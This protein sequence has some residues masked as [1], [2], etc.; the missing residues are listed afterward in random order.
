MSF[1]EILAHAV[2]AKN[3]FGRYGGSSPA[4]FVMGK[5]HP[6]LDGAEAVPPNE[7]STLET[8]LQRKTAAIKAFMESEAKAMLCL[9]LHAR[10]RT[11][12]QPEPG[13]I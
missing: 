11:L 12:L 8:H 13:Q 7:L 2:A 10:S 9:A 1:S 6:L 4:Q 5:G 3:S